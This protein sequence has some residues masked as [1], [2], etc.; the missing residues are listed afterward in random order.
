[1]AYKAPFA[2]Y[3]L[4]TPLHRFANQL[5]GQSLHLLLDTTLKQNGHQLYTAIHTNSYYC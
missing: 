3:L 4:F 1:M 2:A 5:A